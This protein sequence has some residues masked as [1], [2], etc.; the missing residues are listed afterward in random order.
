MPPRPIAREEF[1]RFF[2]RARPP[3]GWPENIGVANSGGPDST[4]LLFLIQ[5]Y[6]ED[7]TPS[8]TSSPSRLVSITVDHDLQASSAQMAAHCARTA[9]SLHVAH[10]SSKVQWGK[11]PFPPRPL[12]S[13]PFEGGARAARYHLLWENMQKESLGALALGHHADDQVE[14]ALMRLGRQS[15]EL[16]GRGMLWCRRW[17]MGV[18]NPLEWAGYE[19]MN[20][21]VIR[22]LLEVSKDRILATC[23][24]NELNYVTDP[25]NF[26]PDITLRNALRS[27]TSAEKPPDTSTFPTRI[28]ES[29]EEIN[30][31]ISAFSNLSID[32]NSP[33]EHLRSAVK[34][35][36]VFAADIE[37]QATNLL[38]K[39]RLPSP[40]GTF[41]VSTRAL[42]NIT[43]P[44]LQRAL[45]LRILRYTSFHPWGSIRAQ[46]RRS[47]HSLDQIIQKVWHPAP[48]YAGIH[49]FVAGGGIVWIPVVVNTSEATPSFL[50]AAGRI[51]KPNPDDVRSGKS[52]LGRGVVGWMAVRQPPPRPEKMREIGLED[53]LNVDL[54]G[55][56]RD[57]MKC[58]DEGRGGGPEV[59][60]VLW[61]CRFLIRFDLGRMPGDV[62]DLLLHDAESEEP[63]IAV[64]W[65]TKYYYPKVVLVPKNGRLAW[66]EGEDKE[67]VL[68]SSIDS[69]KPSTLLALTPG[70]RKKTVPATARL[71]RYKE[72][73]GRGNTPL[74]SSD[75]ISTSWIR[76]LDAS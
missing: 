9:A 72:D 36:D 40:P 59:L 18:K 69:H 56:L 62:K 2:Q 1:A 61:D 54:T 49:P 26:Q 25:T 15:S 67:T 63:K 27:I 14:T 34:S 17:G 6:I 42:Q 5:R 13:D 7:S 32:L 71:D 64:R 28:R 57:G 23:E 65:W 48:F 44:L 8:N 29:L 58:W 4:C 41:I 66:S 53:T 35:I 30:K 73:R 60:E 45:I 51:K 55:V 68:H 10:T 43:N 22:P 52:T 39:T 16:G 24:E 12:P 46:A 38:D 75:W 21:W 3:T 76:T 33:S 74:A 11:P 31:T 20:K 47:R 50:D 70:V 19:G 37:N